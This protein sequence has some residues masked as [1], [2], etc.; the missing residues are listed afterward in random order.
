M[1]RYI[2]I[3]L[4][5]LV[6]CLALIPRLWLW[7]DQGAAG[8]VYP[9]DQDEYY[10]GAIH[11]LLQ[12]DYY[13]DGQ[14]LR[15]PLTSLFLALV[16]ALL[17]NVDI[18]AAM[19]VQCV[20]SALTLPL[21]AA[22][23]RRLF[24]SRGAGVVAALIGAL[25][26]P[27]ASYA[28]QLLSETLCIFTVA[29]SL[30]L[31][32][33]ARQNGLSWRWLFAG[34]VAWGLVSLTRPVAVYALP[35]LMLWAALGRRDIGTDGH[36]HGQGTVSARR[37]SVGRW[38]ASS[39]SPYRAALSALLARVRLQAALVLL[40]GFVLVVAPWTVRNYMVYG[41]FVL[42]DTNGGVSF[43]L[44]N[45]REPCE[46]NLQQVWN[47][48]LPNSAL[49]QQVAIA[50]GLD[51]IR[52]DP[53]TFVK[54]MRYKAVSLWQ[55]D[56]RLFVANAPIGITL[57]ERSLLFALA[58]DVEYVAIVVLALIGVTLSL[59][60]E[61]N[62]VL[63]GWPLYGTLL[64]MITL[65]HPRLRLPL[66][67]AVIIYAALPLAHPRIIWQGIR[68]ATRWQWSF[69]AGS[70]GVFAFLIYASAYIP[71]VQS[72][73]WLLSARLGG[74]EQAI[75]WAR[76]A[77]PDNY[78]PY[79]ALGEHYR[80]QGDTRRA[81][82]TFNAAAERAPQN[83]YTNL[84]RL[85]LSRRLGDN[86]GAQ[87][88]MDAVAAV[89]W[90]NIQTYEWAW[91]H[92]SRSQW[93]ATPV[94]AADPAPGVLRG[95]SAAQHDGTHT[96]RWTA[97]RA[98]VRV[99]LLPQAPDQPQQS[100]LTLV[101]RADKPDTPVAVYWEYDDLLSNHYAHIETLQVGTTWKSYT[102][103]LG[104][105]GIFYDNPFGSTGVVELR[106]PTHVVSVEEP[107]PRGVALAAA[108]LE[109]EQ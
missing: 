39:A 78:L 40:L 24:D 32:E 85:D 57:D 33:I 41:Q 58:S 70:L 87:Q 46:R 99:G 74:G 101:L 73:V 12:G 71:F 28:S 51:N 96:F 104:D 92:L 108:W 8:M 38:V 16:F 11:I 19:L 56:T 60:T 82:D 23:A 5:T 72:Q 31:F 44:G 15:P 89:G 7:Y 49:R 43:W 94:D 26:L 100:R 64:C 62:P 91:K 14:W 6:V 36:G 59:P 77:A 18:P 83:T 53:L 1:S 50:K 93:Q 102:L 29:L 47:E 17:G 37:G 95:V 80:Q 61:R 63:L 79:V 4:L 106:T 10:R 25:F 45:L 2:Y 103:S 3:L 13:D 68:T 75:V 81:L 48:T 98:Q 42:V 76:D 55:L 88:A 54:R 20:L 66:M 105:R 86:D 27:F 22:T 107:Y 109:Y 9:G 97:A 90:D 34:G 52:H 65:G 21:L 35:L 30:L 69:L 84:Q 67:V